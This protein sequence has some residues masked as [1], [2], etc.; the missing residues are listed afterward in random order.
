MTRRLV[1]VVFCWLLA[2]VTVSADAF[3]IEV[4]SKG[5]RLAM[6][7]CASCH[8]V[9][10]EQETGSADAPPFKTIAALPE[11]ELARLPAFLADPHPKMPNYALSR[12]EIADLVAYI[13]SLKP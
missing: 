12:Q 3:A 2:V 9:T 7:W 10:P 1:L 11:E 8:I 4:P 6:Q 13:R 5:K